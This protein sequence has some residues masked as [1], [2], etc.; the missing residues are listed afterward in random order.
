MLLL[1][2]KRIIKSQFTNTFIHST[3]IQLCAGRSRKGLEPRSDFVSSVKKAFFIL[4]RA[5]LRLNPEDRFRLLVGN[6]FSRQC[7]R[8]ILIMSLFVNTPT[9]P[10]MK[11]VVH[12]ERERNMYR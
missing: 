12:T 7:Q 2:Y 3:S 11:S 1:E 8:N 10:L 6:Y 5:L 9:G 4:V